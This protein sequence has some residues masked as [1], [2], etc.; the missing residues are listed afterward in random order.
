MDAED[1][2]FSERFVSTPSSQFKY[3]WQDALIYTAARELFEETGLIFA[4]AKQVEVLRSLAKI[5]NVKYSEIFAETQPELRDIFIPF[6]RLI[7]I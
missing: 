6:M 2:A 1:M 5:D 4:R 7:T 3:K